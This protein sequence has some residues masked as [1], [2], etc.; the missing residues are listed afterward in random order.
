MIIE[1]DGD[2]AQ[3]LSL[4][5]D[6]VHKVVRSSYISHKTLSQNQTSTRTSSDLIL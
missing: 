3:R 5:A 6:M 4:L 1:L 2:T